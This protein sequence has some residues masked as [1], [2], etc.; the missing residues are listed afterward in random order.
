MLDKDEE[1]KRRGLYARGLRPLRRGGTE[2]YSARQLNPGVPELLGAPYIDFWPRIALLAGAFVALSL[3]TPATAGCN[4][5]NSKNTA[6]LT[7]LSCQGDASG[8][9]ALAIGLASW[10]A[11]A[12]ATAIGANRQRK[13]CQSPIVSGK[14]RCRM[15]GGAMGS[16]APTGESNGSYRHG[17]YTAEALAAKR[18]LR[19]WLRAS[20]QWAAS[21]CDPA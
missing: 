11:G 19:D 13:P 8:D 2:L 17:R 15:H 7:S 16:G 20:R 10:A 3:A 21:I 6:L 5:G 14:K 9:H 12:N 18:K 1:Q 4:S